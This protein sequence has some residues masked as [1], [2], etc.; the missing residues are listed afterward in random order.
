MRIKWAGLVVCAISL[1]S[2]YKVLDGKLKEH[3]Q[4]KGTDGSI[5]LK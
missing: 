5:I 2:S 4:K 1:R 3:L